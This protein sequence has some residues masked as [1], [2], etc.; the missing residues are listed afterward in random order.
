MTRTLVLDIE[1]SP[2]VGHI[3]GLWNQNIS[4]SQLMESGEVLCFAAQWDGEKKIHFHSTHKDGRDGMLLAAHALFTEADVIVGWNSKRFDVPW[5]KG[6]WAR[7]GLG[8]PA[9]YMQIDLCNVV[10]REF[11]LPSNKLDYV[12]GEL[13]GEHKKATGGHGLWVACMNGDDK[14]W[15]TMEKYNKADVVLTGKL[16]TRLRPWITN[17]PHPG[18]YDGAE[19]DSCP[20]CGGSNLVKRGFAY[21]TLSRYQRYWCPDCGRWARGGKRLSGVD[22]R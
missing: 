18:L 16:L 1:T 17:L 22:A 3:W 8:P 5:L 19:P 10:K 2:N 12:A 14:A 9:P 13:L 21:T 20:D 15:A 11:R 7:M 4:L 6:E